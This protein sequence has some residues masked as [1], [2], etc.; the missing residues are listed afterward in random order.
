MNIV[1]ELGVFLN[2]FWENFYKISIE[3]QIEEKSNK[4][5]NEKEQRERS[6]ILTSIV[7][8]MCHIL[9]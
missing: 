6:L 8:I 5:C 3:N 2:N 4:N 1:C 9:S 7:R